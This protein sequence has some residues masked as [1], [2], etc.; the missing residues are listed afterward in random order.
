MNWFSYIGQGHLPRDVAAHSGLGP[1]ISVNNQDEPPPIDLC[2]GR[3]G[4]GISSVEAFPSD[5]SR[6]G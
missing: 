5:D 1:S 3:S 6:L 4:L 2:T